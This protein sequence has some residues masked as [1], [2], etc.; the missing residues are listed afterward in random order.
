MRS[1]RTQ[2]SRSIEDAARTAE[3]RRILQAYI[4]DLRAIVKKL[5]PTVH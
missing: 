3:A 5:G 1:T 4:E 2:T